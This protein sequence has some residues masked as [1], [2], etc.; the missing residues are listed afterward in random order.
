MNRTK[1]AISI[2]VP[3]VKKIRHAVAQ[4]RAPSVSAYITTVL[5]A[6]TR[7]TA[8]MFEL[9]DEM[10][11]KHGKPGAEAYRWARRVLAL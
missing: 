2:P 7:G 9:L 5:E 10:D 4:G 3:L 11:R 8:E 1:I 6:H